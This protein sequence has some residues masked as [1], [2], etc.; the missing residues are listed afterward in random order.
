[1][2]FITSTWGTAGY[3]MGA[4]SLLVPSMRIAPLATTISPPSTSSCIPPQV[5]TRRKVWAPHLDN[6]SIAIA[7][8]GPPMPVD[9]TLTF[10][11][12]MVPVYVVYSRLSATNT[13]FSK[14]SAIFLHRLGSPGMMTYPPISSGPIPV[15]YCFPVPSV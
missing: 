6:S 11:P 5:P 13:G 1:M 3:S 12:S 10:T 15:W 9:V 4:Y 7:A 14:C 8:D 2:A